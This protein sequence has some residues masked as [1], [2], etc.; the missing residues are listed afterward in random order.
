M[1]T[2]QIET[3]VYHLRYAIGM[4]TQDIL[5][6]RANL[7]ILPKEQGLWLQIKTILKKRR[8]KHDITH[9]VIVRA[10]QHGPLTNHIEPILCQITTNILV[11]N[12]LTIHIYIR[13]LQQ[14]EFHLINYSVLKE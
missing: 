14:I 11:L 3:L 8:L 5:Y 2:I 12:P 6:K 4:W 10:Y 1:I 9:E 13:I 7:C